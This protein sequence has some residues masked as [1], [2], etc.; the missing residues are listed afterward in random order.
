M[1]TMNT[2]TWANDSGF[3]KNALYKSFDFA[4]ENPGMKVDFLNISF[5]LCVLGVPGNLLITGQGR[6]QN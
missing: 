2:S 5:L 6:P 3:L 4:A 1:E